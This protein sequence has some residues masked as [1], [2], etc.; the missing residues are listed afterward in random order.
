[1]E[2]QSIDRALRAVRK[3]NEIRHKQ[4][5]KIDILC[6]DMVSANRDII[7]QLNL[8]TSAVNFYES[9]TGQTDISNLL[10]IAAGHIRHMVKNSNVA[11]FLTDS[12][13]FEIH[14]ADDSPIEIDKKQFESY[15][16]PEVVNDICRSSRVCSIEDM[17]NIGLQANPAVLSSISAAAVPLGRFTQPVGFILIYRKA[18]NNLTAE[19]LEKVTTI[20]PGLRNAITACR[21]MVTTS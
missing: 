16:T 12:N 8:L 14:M 13:G 1:M 4:D 17:C 5:Q 11:V 21:E 20:T 7:E 3:L 9:I 2:K 10:D 15:F 18:E 19:E 6:N